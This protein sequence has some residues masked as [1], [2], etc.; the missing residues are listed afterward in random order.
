MMW[1]SA[2]S[3]CFTVQKAHWQMFGVPT[4]ASTHI[5]HHIFFFEPSTRDILTIFGD[6]LT[7][8]RDILTIFRDIFTI[9]R[10]ILT[11][12]EPSTALHFFE[13]A[14]V[15][16]AVAPTEP[17]SIRDPGSIKISSATSK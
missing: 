17:L 1:I 3:T 4:F 15:V 7:I 14:M 10:D 6:I 13:L 5:H 11:I 16:A 2:G 12:Y 9:F 8:F